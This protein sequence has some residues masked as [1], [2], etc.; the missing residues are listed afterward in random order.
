MSGSPSLGGIPLVESNFVSSDEAVLELKKQIPVDFSFV[1]DFGQLIKEPL[2][3]EDERIGCLNIHPSALPLYRGAA[4]IQR[5]LM[6]GADSIGVTVFKLARKMDSGPI[7]LSTAVPV[8]PADD[9]GSIRTKAATAGVA[10]FVRFV[11]MYPAD[12]WSF[13]PQ[14]EESVTYAPKISPGEERIDWNKTSRDITRQIC[15]LSPKP[16][17]WT[18]LRGKRLLVLSARDASGDKAGIN[19]APGKLYPDRRPIVGTGE[20]LLEL[21]TVQAEGKKPQPASSWKNGLRAGSEEYLV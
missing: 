5:A 6:N 3:A 12:S 18:T 14:N 20:G 7:L 16:G 10:A 2:L 4:P 8:A 19:Y 13:E 11:S 9:F 21:V 17:A 1:I 15:A